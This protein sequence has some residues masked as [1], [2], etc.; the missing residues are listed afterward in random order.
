MT[1]QWHDHYEAGKLAFNEK[2]YEV[3]K[4]HFAEVIGVK[5][6]F[7]DVHNMLGLISFDENFY[8]DAIKSFERALE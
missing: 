7:A 6:N 1:M 3:A 5:D 4:E 2:N 8:D